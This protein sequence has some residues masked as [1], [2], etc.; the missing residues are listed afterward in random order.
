M[1]AI[2]LDGAPENDPAGER[3][4]AALLAELQERGWDVQTFLLREQKI[5]NCAGD[6]FCWVRSPGVC[7]VDDDNRAIAAAIANSDLL[8][9]LTPVTFG[10]YSSALKRMVDHQIQNI[11]PFFAQVEGEVHHR[12]RYK[13][14]PDFLAVGWLEAPDLQ[15]EAVFR[16]L[17]DRNRRNFYARTSIAGLV[18]ANQSQGELR[19]MVQGWLDDLANCKSSLTMELP[20]LSLASQ[21]AGAPKKALLLVGSPRTKKSTSY[22]LGSYLLEQLQAE[23]IQVETRYIHTSLRSVDRWNDVLL[24]VDAA[25]LVL[26]AFPLYVDTLP[27]PV[28]E[29]LERIAARRAALAPLRSQRF[30]AIINC[31]F[32]EAQ[33]MENA[34]AVCM[35]FTRQAGFQWAGALALA[36]GEGLVHGT[37]LAELDGRAIPLKQS[38]EMAALAL[39]QGESIPQEATD[40]LAKPVIPGW[41][42]RM[43]GGYGWKQMAKRYGMEK[44]LRRQPY[45]D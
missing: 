40:L 44:Q 5:G 45:L 30:A 12:K 32:P 29:A 39:A 8:V 13:S 17:V 19:R 21:T 10:G 4:Q 33:H 24:A 15:A 7:N 38:L 41:L 1:K 3:L 36:G 27:A 26:L 28:I 20:D 11:S 22:A 6:F 23:G 35:L 9:Y 16:H 43:F 18:Y 34:K 25:D 37:P 42:Y 2:L 14:Y 31:G